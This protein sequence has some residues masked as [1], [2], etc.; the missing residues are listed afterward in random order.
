MRSRSVVGCEGGLGETSVRLEVF[1]NWYEACR[2]QGVV[3]L[4]DAQSYPMSQTLEAVKHCVFELLVVEF[5]RGSGV[6][7]VVG[8]VQSVY[9]LRHAL[10]GQ[11]R[12]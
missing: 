7:G 3:L 12:C 5:T 8:H 4:N 1:S 2:V 10:A 6:V 9:L 11:E